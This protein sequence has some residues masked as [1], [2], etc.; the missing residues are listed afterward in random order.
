MI[1]DPKM[2]DIYRRE[3]SSILDASP[4]SI[5]EETYVGLEGS[6]NAKKE[7]KGRI[8][9]MIEEHKKMTNG[10]ILS[11]DQASNV[12]YRQEM[13]TG[14]VSNM[15]KSQI[16]SEMGQTAA[17]HMTDRQLSKVYDTFGKN[18]IDKLMN[19]KKGL[20]GIFE[21]KSDK[22][23]SKLTE[24][25]AEGNS[26]LFK[27]FSQT[28]QGRSMDWEGLKHMKDVFGQNT[29]NPNALG[30][31]IKVETMVSKDSTGMLRRTYDS[32]SQINDL[33]QKL[34]DPNITPELY[35]EHKQDLDDRNLLYGTK[36][37]DFLAKYPDKEAQIND[38]ESI[39]SKGN[40][41]KE[42][43]KGKKK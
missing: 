11:S 22:E 7:A 9:K 33:K 31:K 32:L 3:I 30:Q 42:N 6:E 14:D 36:K 5:D 41:G 8:A 17:L 26:R 19:G 29:T 15:T 28:Q 34:K 1:K 25:I 24:A 27:F 13:K 16:T 2:K 23:M 18:V 12:L 35:S 40:A 21:G 43:K 38:L 4:D 37:K 20:N 10:E 39:L